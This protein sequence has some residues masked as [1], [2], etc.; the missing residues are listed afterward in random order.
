MNEYYAKDAC[1]EPV[2]QVVVLKVCR[3][4]MINY[5]YLVADPC[6]NGAVVVDPAWEMEKIEQAL[7]DTGSVLSGILVTHA[8]PDHIHL[9]VPLAAEY[10]CPVWM[11]HEEIAVSGFR[12]PQL[13]G[14]KA[15]P[16]SVGNLRIEPILT[17]G[18]TPG[19]MC[20]LIGDNL[21]TGDTLFAEGCGICP[22]ATAAH[23]LYD[24]LTHLKAR[25]APHVKVFPGH[26]YGK[27]PGQQ[28]SQLLKENIYLQF[29]NEAHFAAYR[30][31]SRQDPRKMFS[32]I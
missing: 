22:D 5:S 1:P 31:R 4:F 7:T 23:V 18:H 21:F 3:Q 29:N 8:H 19:G 6:G 15:I 30:L 2:P 16:W 28:F 14:I 10:G 32:F 27:P 20:Y 9:A 25:V 11:S 17:P 26:R 13:T 24:S 12:C